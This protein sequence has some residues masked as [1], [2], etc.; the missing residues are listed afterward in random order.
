M[1]E[2]PSLA[3]LTK[4]ELRKMVDTRAGFWLQLAV[5]GLT[6]VATLIAMLAGN[7]GDHT[8]REILKVSVQPAGILLPVVGI[9]LVSS[10]W[11]QR[12]AMVSFA[13]VPDRGRLIAAKA[14]AGVVLGIV[15]TVV[16]VLF[17]A[18]GTAL[19]GSSAP[20]VWTMPL[21]LLGQD[22][23]YVVTA[24]LTGVGFGAALLASAPAIV[25]YFGLPAAFGAL[26]SIHALR[27]P[28]EWV[29][30][31][32]LGPLTE[33]LLGGTAWG[34]VATTLLLWMALPLAIGYWRITRRDLS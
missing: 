9:L 20:G 5:L 30:T 21:G 33:G 34:Q 1:N 16:A 31:E 29:T 13:L 19:A 6:V 18:I 4:V 11:S 17:A 22:L 10:E 27:K 26:G 2:R 7:D 3:R 8:F 14:L 12:T 25:L 15:A 28:A 23:L 24:M 32:S